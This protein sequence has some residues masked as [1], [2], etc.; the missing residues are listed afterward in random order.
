MKVTKGAITKVDTGTK[1]VVVKSAD[2]TEKTFEYTGNAAKDMGEAVGK[3]TEKG[4]K[5]T[6]Y[7]T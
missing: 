6:V 3:G 1:A 5:V 4:T 7:H 2:G